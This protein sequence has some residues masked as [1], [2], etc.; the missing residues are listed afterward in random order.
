MMPVLALGSI[1]AAY[2][3]TQREILMLR[4]VVQQTDLT[5]LEKLEC[6]Q[7]VDVLMVCCSLASFLH[8]GNNLCFQ[9]FFYLRLE[10][11]FGES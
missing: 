5:K 4:N 6:V 2:D 1:T 7:C 10:L 8:Q 9:A 3:K 11:Q